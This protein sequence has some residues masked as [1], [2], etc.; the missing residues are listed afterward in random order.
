LQVN[1]KV[2]LFATSRIIPEIEKNF[3]NCLLLEIRANPE[4]I[5]NYLDQHMS[6]LPDFV[7]KDIN[8]QTEIKT[9]I[10]GAIDGMLVYYIFLTLLRKLIIIQ[11]SSR[12]AIPRFISWKEVTS[13]SQNSA[14]RSTESA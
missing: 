2:N 4:D 9:N 5:W 11:V 13:S 14:K 7:S 1:S 8:L 12:A 3:K 6:Q 10:E